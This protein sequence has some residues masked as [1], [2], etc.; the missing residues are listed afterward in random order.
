MKL[1][2]KKYFTFR[3][4]D[5]IG[6]ITLL[7]IVLIVFLINL[8]LPK[9]VKNEQ[10]FNYSKFSA[11]IDSFMLSLNDEQDEE[12]LS[13]LDSF[14]IARY[15]TLELF[16]FDPNFTTD[17]QWI[18]LGLTEKQINTINNYKDRGGEFYIK[19]DFRK[20]YGIRTMQYKLLRPYIDLPEKLDNGYKNNYD[21]PDND[22]ENY[23]LFEFDPNNAT[24]DD[25]KKLG[26]SKRVI[27]I[28]NNY[29]NKGGVF[30]KKQDFK[31]IY[32]I[33]DKLYNRLE[34][35]IVINDKKKTKNKKIP[36]VE[37]NTA[38]TALFKT[39]PGIG[40]VLSSRIIKFRD[41][42]G[43]FYKISQINQVYGLSSQTYNKIKPYLK[44]ETGNLIKIN[45]NFADYYDLVKHPYID[46]KTANSI[47]DYREKNGFYT[48]VSQLKDNN[49]I[50]QIKYKK[51][52]KYLSTK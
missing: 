44:I 32:G 21:F 45:I 49:I 41:K 6:I 7:F 51:L 15:D 17:E 31:K 43:G 25:F 8:F 22:S 46:S 12:Y 39:L 52:K 35:Y 11:Q 50:D 23:T 36:I 20:I 34:P 14:I 29:R 2:L 27:N 48:S 40:S 4:N 30:Y 24:N 18:K 28:I 38:D 37:I 5:R 1:D 10:N 26:I 16:M 42:L 3:K 19:D 9:F 33:N 47:I 13:K